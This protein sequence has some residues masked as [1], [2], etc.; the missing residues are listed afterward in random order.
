[1]REIEES[2]VKVIGEGPGKA[3]VVHVASGIALGRVERENGNWGAEWTATTGAGTRI[4][5]SSE[6]RS[7]AVQD[8]LDPDEHRPEPLVRKHSRAE[9]PEDAHRRAYPEE[10]A[11]WDKVKPIFEG[12]YD[13]KED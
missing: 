4:S 12:S 7:Y 9:V 2:E 5:G 8:L 10:W 1:M 13:P 11:W 6:T 3:R